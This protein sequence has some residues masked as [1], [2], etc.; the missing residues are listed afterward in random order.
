VNKFLIAVIML[1]SAAFAQ[2]KSLSC[3]DTIAAG[4]VEHRFERVSIYNGTA[5][6]KE[7]ELAPDEGKDSAGPKIVQAWNLKDYR[8]MNIFLRCRYHD[9]DVVKNLDAPANL[10]TCTLTFTLD[11][12]GVYVGKSTLLCR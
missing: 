2:T 5:G 11:K 12:K 1:Q 3:P 9:T 8:S 4:K 6:G 7:F 10:Q